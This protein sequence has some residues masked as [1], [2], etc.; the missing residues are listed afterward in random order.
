[1]NIRVYSPYFPF[2]PNEGNFLTVFDQIFSLAERHSV[3]L[4][5]WLNSA[6]DVRERQQ[7]STGVG[8]PSNVR[9]RHLAPPVDG[10]P[11][12][13]KVR[14]LLGGLILGCASAESFYYPEWVRR[15]FETLP[16]TQLEIYH[17]TAAYPALQRARRTNVSRVCM[18]HDLN[19]E[20]YQ[21]R[22]GVAWGGRR[23]FYR[24]NSELL[25]RH[26]AGLRTLA[27]ELW[28]V[29]PVELN[30]FRTLPG[31]AQLRLTPPTFNLLLSA[32]RRMEFSLQS[33]S[34]SPP[35]FGLIGD[36]R[37]VPN[38][39]SL[40]FLLKEVCPLLERL[41]FGGL[42]RVV[43]KGCP[44]HIL[45]LARRYD[46]VRIEGFIA[47]LTEF[48]SSLSFMLVPHVSGTGVRMKLL[49][50]LAFGVPVLAHREAIARIHPD[51]CENPLI[52]AEDA[53]SAW[54]K[55]MAAERAGL[56][57]GRHQTEP[58]PKELNG[59]HVYGFLEQGFG[60]SSLPIEFHPAQK[61]LER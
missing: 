16:E 5:V 19:S 25:K 6:Q 60:L 36:L 44:P 29:T 41:R 47:D 46:F 35:I 39:M 17:H 61:S 21:Q 13:R 11:R 7:R 33:A 50:A 28:F 22:A 10:W 4:V 31:A 45:D 40:E 38:L 51:M 56:R 57:R 37:H 48:Y 1:M 59:R 14:R 43:G 52:T 30:H 24:Y 55:L 32:Q 20:L 26:E 42:I 34:S 58:P 53:P 23:W 54:A 18:V 49:E 3:E 9:L 2:P 15:Q 8:F 27:D 12:I